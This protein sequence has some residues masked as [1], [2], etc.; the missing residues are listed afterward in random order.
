MTTIDDT[1]T[2]TDRALEATADRV[3]AAARAMGRPHRH[4]GD[5]AVAWQADRGVFTNCAVVMHS[6]DDWDDLLARIADVVPTGRPVSLVS[7]ATTADLAGRGWHLVGHPPLM[8]RAA[9]GEGPPCPAE[10]TIAEAVD[11][12]ALEVFERT[13]VDSYPDP[14]LQPYA[15]GS[16]LDGRALGG[17]THF[18]TGFVAGRPVATAVG[19]VAAGVNLVEMVATAADARGRGYG[20]ALTWAATTVEPTLPAVLIASDLGRP[21]YEALGYHAVS[22]WTFWHRP[23]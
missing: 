4:D 10:L 8:A 1:R 21:V 3:L 18:S 15:W 11:E 23:A 6:P 17:A 9:G 22:R 7:A 12:A 19:H 14:T 2:F 13:L 16:L 20:A 5:L